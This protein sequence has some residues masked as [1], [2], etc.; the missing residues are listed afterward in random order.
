MPVGTSA[1]EIADI[2]KEL[3]ERKNE[4]Q[5][6][7]LILGSRAGGLFRSQ[8]FYENMLRYSLRN[9]ADLTPRE[10]FSQC[11]EI[12]DKE[13]M[14]RTD[15]RIII[16]TALE[17]LNF[18]IADDCLAELVKQRLFEFIFT[19]NVDDLLENAFAGSRMKE[20]HDFVVFFPERHSSGDILHHEKLYACKLI[21]MCGELQ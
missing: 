6:P 8:Y 18:T 17:N 10:Q 1:I 14:S 12:L 2:A 5:R 21:K 15:L 16:N 3:E 7:V 11:Y 20:A 19:N 4:N 13:A 9:F